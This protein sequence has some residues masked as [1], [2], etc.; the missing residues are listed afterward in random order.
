M[1]ALSRQALW[2]RLS[3][4]GVVT[5][6]VPDHGEQR[7]PWFVRAMLGIAGWIGALFLLAFV[8]VGFVFVMKSAAASMVVGAGACAVAAAIFRAAPRNDFIA[9]FGLAVSLAGQ[10]L[11]VF[12]LAQSFGRSTAVIAF[13]IAFQ[14]ALLFVL[15]PNFV[16]RVWASWTGAVAVSFALSNMGL[17]GYTPTIV[18]AALLGT[19]LHEFDFSRRGELVR[20]GGYGLALAAVQTAVLSGGFRF[21][22]HAGWPP[23]GAEIAMWLVP[24]AGGAVLLW[25]VVALLKR[26]GVPLDTGRGRFA[27]A[28]AVI[29]GLISFK[30]PGVGPA[31]AILIVGYANGNRMLAGLGIFA[32]LG[33]LSQ[34]YYSLQATL[35]EKSM[36]LAAAGAA[37]LLA[38]VALRRLWPVSGEASHA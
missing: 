31:V 5:G 23:V 20:A 14:Q 32:L 29:L 33:Y 18:T 19:W 34:Y 16:H 13:L 10:A 38:R 36:M 3:E 17:Y 28:C 12:G 27:V 4:A 9:Q 7:S 30:A 25:A 11:L 21:W 26:E 15:V 37:L 6:D 24:I 8:G 35:L 2:I 1:S 22:L